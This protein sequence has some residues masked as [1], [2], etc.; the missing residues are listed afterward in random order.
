MTQGRT[1]LALSNGLEPLKAIVIGN[2]HTTPDCNPRELNKEFAQRNTL[3]QKCQGL[4]EQPTL[5]LPT[6]SRRKAAITAAGRHLIRS[7]P[8]GY[9]RMKPNLAARHAI[10]TLRIPSNHVALH[11]GPPNG[12]EQRVK[13]STAKPSRGMP[14]RNTRPSLD[15]L[16][17]VRG[18]SGAGQP[19][20]DCGRMCIAALC[21]T[22]PPQAL[23]HTLRPSRSRDHLPD[24]HRSAPAATR[25]GQPASTPAKR[26]PADHSPDRP[27]AS[28]RSAQR[29]RDP[30]CHP[31]H[32]WTSTA[33]QV[34]DN[35]G[36]LYQATRQ[37]TKGE[38]EQE[39]S[40]G[41]NM[42]NGTGTRDGTSKPGAGPPRPGST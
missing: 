6:V 37:S 31:R 38:E 27:G 23:S 21:A 3:N 1:R 32:Q 41:N 2:T 22:D 11:Q 15:T 30:R 28:A 34:N 25:A 40:T 39:D 17:E 12:N 36:R 18:G 5:M 14:D 26:K 4:S 10:R 7:S 33:K 8:I 24:G 29:G 42:K 16:A 20:S 9:V 19:R 13:P 35:P